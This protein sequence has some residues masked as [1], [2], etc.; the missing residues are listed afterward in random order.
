M[1]SKGADIDGE[2]NDDNSGRVVSINDAGTIV[3]IGAHKND[4]GGS[5][6]GHVRVYEW[7][8]TAWAQ[9]VAI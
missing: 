4:G 8:G 6:A 7:N 3:A 1:G 2:A 5:N 9:R